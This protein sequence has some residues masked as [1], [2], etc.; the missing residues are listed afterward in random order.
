MKGINMNKPKTE[1]P[2]MMRECQRKGGD[3]Y[4]TRLVIIQVET[5]RAAIAM[6]KALTRLAAVLTAIRG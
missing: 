3:T 5:R 6:S 4:R 2:E 1:M